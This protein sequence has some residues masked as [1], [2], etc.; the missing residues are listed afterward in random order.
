MRRELRRLL[1]RVNGQHVPQNLGFRTPTQ[2]RRSRRL[3]KLP[4]HFSLDLKTIPVAAGKITFLHC[5]RAHGHVGVLGESLKVGPRLRFDHV[6]ITVEKHTQRLKVYHNG[7]LIKQC[8]F[9]LH[10]S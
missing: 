6:K 8:V 3:Q 2:Y 9:K 1:L 4:A 7:R 10:I 5:A